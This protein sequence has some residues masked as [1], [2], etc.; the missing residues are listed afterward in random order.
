MK[1]FYF[2]LI[3]VFIIGCKEGK[4]FAD[5]IVLSFPKETEMKFQKFNE[6]LEEYSSS[7]I[8]IGKVKDT[9]PVKYYPSI[10][11]A[12]TPLPGF[13]LKTKKET[14]DS[15]TLSE[16]RKKYF[17]PK[18][19]RNQYSDKPIKFDSLTNDLLEIVVKP[20][21]TIP[22]FVIDSTKKIKAYKAFPVFVKNISGRKLK[23]VVDR[24]PGTAIF[25]KNKKW[26]IIK[27]DYFYVCGDGMF[28]HK[29]WILNPDEIIIYS[30]NY[31]EGKQKMKFKVGLTP[32]FFSKEFE[33]NINPEIIKRQRNIY[34][35]K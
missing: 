12:P 2:V 34:E 3:L 27:N 1:T 5:D 18:F 11:L 24:Y 21:D 10:Y 19:D 28:M 13:K 8:Y 30:V 16:I 32:T 33:G 22:H 26:Q 20:E 23:M 7:I 6:G 15:I 9:I 31:F 35:I 4:T 14:E 25:N 29:Y 17:F